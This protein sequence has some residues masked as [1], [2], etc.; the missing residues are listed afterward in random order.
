MLDVF[1]Q[2]ARFPKLDSAIGR[3]NTTGGEAVPGWQMSA[4]WNETASQKDGTIER[5]TAFR[6]ITEM[7]LQGPHIHVGSPLYKTPRSISSKKGD[8]D[9][10][11]LVAAPDN[12]LPR[13]N[14]GPAV[15]TTEYRRRMTRCRWDATKAHVDFYRLAFRSMVAMN[16]ERSLIPALLPARVAHVD[17]IESAAFADEVNLLTVHTLAISLLFDF[18]MKSSLRAH[19]RDA[20]FRQLPIANPGEG[21]IHR[22]LRLACLTVA[23]ADVWNRHASNLQPLPWSSDDSRLALEGPV[24]GPKEWDRTAALRTEFAR[25]M[26]L[27]EIDV[28]VAQAFG[29]TVDQLIEIY[30]I[31]F[32]VLQENDSGTWFDQRGRI[33]WTCSKGLPGVGWLDDKGKS[34]GRAAWEKI[35]SS[36]PAELE[37]IVSDGTYPVGPQMVTRRFVGPFTTC[38]RIED[39]RRAWSHFERLR[40]GGEG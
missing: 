19:V 32:P 14:Y 1:R 30:R 16:G 8:Y 4:C 15:N 2:V 36:N 37:C 29:L 17:L 11:D 21:A 34:P 35:L 18:N 26:A 9:V 12:Y 25:R 22:G 3:V 23:Y 13:T 6:P 33:V 10:V 28:L 5:N 38:D 7:V 20:E 40:A 24:E 31:Y 27:V 39:Y